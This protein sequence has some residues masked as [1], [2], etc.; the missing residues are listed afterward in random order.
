MRII[1][2]SDCV[3]KKILTRRDFLK[4]A[5]ATAIV[6]VPATSGYALLR[7]AEGDTPLAKSPYSEMEPTG[8]DASQNETG[9]SILLL[10]PDQSDNP[11]GIYLSEILRAEGLNQFQIA[12]LSSTSLD[13][14]GRY[15]IVLLAEGT[16]N[17]S[18][19]EMLREY[20]AKGGRLV[21]MRP[22]GLLADLFGVEHLSGALEE[23]YMQV[24]SAHPLADGIT[25]EA[26]QYHGKADLFRLTGGQA[27]A[28]L[29]ED[30]QPGKVYPAVAIHH[31][32]EGRTALWSFDLARSVAMMRQGNPR[33]SNQEQDGFNGIRTVDL[34]VDW[35]DLDRIAIPQADEQQRLLANLLT[36]LSQQKRPLPRLWYFP[37]KAEGILVATGD[38][39]MNPAPFIEDVLSRFDKHHG[40]MSVYYSPVLENDLGRAIRR[41][42][43]WITDHIPKV[44]EL[45]GGMYGSPTPSMVSQWRARGHEFTLHPWVEDGLE[46]G[47]NRYWKEFTGRGYGPVSTTVR[48]HRILWSGWVETARFQATRGIRMNCDYYHVGPSLQTKAGEWVYGHLNGSGRPMKFVDEQGQILDIYQQLTQLTDEHLIAMDVPGWG[49]WPDLSAVEAVEVSKLLLDRSVKQGDHTAITAQFHVDPFQVGGEAAQKASIFLE[50]TLS[51]AQ[52]L[53]IPIW[54]ADEWLNFSDI[55]H[56]TKLVN[57]SWNAETKRLQFD[58]DA[59]TQSD[60]ILTVMVPIRHNDVNLSAVEVDGSRSEYIERKLGATLY[61]CVPVNADAHQFRAAYV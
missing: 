39:H 6:A 49:G 51:Y 33:L 22:D 35:I 23:G 48:T 44:G 45:L 31:F 8:S 28:W 12:R 53:G 56:K 36:E 27:I 57:I 18:Q 7:E 9:A 24:D 59:P 60:Q 61:A 15:D 55:R 38:S 13:A 34:F 46:N 4:I 20:V 16:L 10:V 54:S 30:G 17:T 19:G 32:G 11:F 1:E 50:G 29:S 25:T 58:L 14:L 42:R 37:I 47:W 43:F 26:I 40:H 3:N 21:A 41:V 2:G 52:E 5:G